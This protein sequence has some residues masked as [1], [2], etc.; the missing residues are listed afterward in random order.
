VSFDYVE[1]VSGPPTVRDKIN[2]AI[3][4]L[5]LARP[6][7]DLAS[8]PEDYAQRFIRNYQES[9]RMFAGQR[10]FLSKTVKVLRATPPVF[11]LELWEESYAG[12]AHPSS[13]T[14]ARKLSLLPP[15]SRKP[16]WISP[17]INSR[18]SDNYGFTGTSLLFFYNDYEVEPRSMGATNLEIPHVEIRSLL[19]PGFIK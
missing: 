16:T 5:Q 17:I 12:G 3:V 11:S 1:A 13:S 4:R 7:G 6:G 2:S 15:I 9:P 10:W 18:L 19:R 14:Q 8:L